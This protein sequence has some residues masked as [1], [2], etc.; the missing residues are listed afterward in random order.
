MTGARE[1]KSKLWERDPLDWYVEP[2]EATEALLRVAFPQL[3]WLR[4]EAA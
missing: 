2:P 3:G 1:K 4:K